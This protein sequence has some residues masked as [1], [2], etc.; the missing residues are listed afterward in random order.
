MKRRVV[1][2]YVDPTIKPDG[3]SDITHCWVG[4]SAPVEEPIQITTEDGEVVDMDV[5]EMEV[6]DSEDLR[7]GINARLYLENM[8]K[9]EGKA[10]RFKQGSVITPGIRKTAFLKSQVRK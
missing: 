10:P 1:R 9:L 7:G 6:L 4:L 3:T 5:Y 2:L 8:E